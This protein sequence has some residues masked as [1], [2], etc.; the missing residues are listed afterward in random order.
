MLLFQIK[1]DVTIKRE[2]NTGWAKAGGRHGDTRE[3][4]EAHFSSCF[5]YLN[6]L[7]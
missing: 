6:V 1:S 4:G 2:R 7:V 3:E 5:A